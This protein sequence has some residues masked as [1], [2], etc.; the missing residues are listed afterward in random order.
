MNRSKPFVPYAMILLSK[1][2]VDIGNSQISKGKPSFISADLSKNDLSQAHSN[3]KVIGPYARQRRHQACPPEKCY[4][5][6]GK[7]NVALF[8]VEL[9][10]S[11]HLIWSPFVLAHYSS[12]TFSNEIKKLTQAS[13]ERLKLVQLWGSTSF[14]VEKI[15]NCKGQPCMRTAIKVNWAPFIIFNSLVETNSIY[16]WAM[17]EIR[18]QSR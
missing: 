13:R 8:S 2:Q 12:A 18:H 14:Q 7:V 15:S 5:L 4:H 10:E 3:P 17:I 16:F 1:Q 6:I 11:F 9:R